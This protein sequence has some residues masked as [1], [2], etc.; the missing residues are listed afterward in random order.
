MKATRRRREGRKVEGGNT[1]R[2]RRGG[3]VNEANE[4]HLWEGRKT[5]SATVKEEGSK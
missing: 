5:G 3:Q 2:S 1:W 4:A